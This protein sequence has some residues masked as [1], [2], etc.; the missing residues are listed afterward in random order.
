VAG[1]TSALARALT[2]FELFVGALLRIP[3]AH[4]LRWPWSNSMTAD[5]PNMT[6]E[7]L[8]TTSN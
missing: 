7:D 6:A 4:D 1:T 2:A 5:D 3:D 8:K